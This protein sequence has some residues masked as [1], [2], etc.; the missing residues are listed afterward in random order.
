MTTDAFDSVVKFAPDE[1]RNWVGQ[2]RR[3]EVIHQHGFRIP[4]RFWKLIDGLPGAPLAGEPLDESAVW[5]SRGTLFDLAEAAR[6]DQSGESALRL[7]WATLAWGT[8]SPNRNNKRRVEAI[9][10]NIGEAG[11]VL[12]ESAELSTQDPYA[13]FM[14]LHP[15]GRNRLGFLGPS[16]STKFLY[17]AGGGDPKHPCQIVDSKALATTYRITGEQAFDMPHGR[18][19]YDVGTYLRVLTRFEELA[20]SASTN[21]RT[22]SADEV[23]RWAFSA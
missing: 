17:F 7:Y 21:K 4:L 18:Y 2:R 20:E 12:Q 3:E 19:N 13:A 23:E 22:I 5:I 15:R 16:F 11:R 9:R 14:L 1:I 10:G 8:G 6:T